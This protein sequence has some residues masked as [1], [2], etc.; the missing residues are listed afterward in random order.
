MPKISRRSVHFM[1]RFCAAGI[2]VSILCSGC[3]RGRDAATVASSRTGQAI[4]GAQSQR[5]AP[6]AIS[7]ADCPRTGRWALCSVEKR[8]EQS[9]FVVSR[10]ETGAHYRVGFSVV[11]VT[12]TLGRAHLEVFLYPDAAAA[13]REVAGLDTATAG[14]RGSRSQWP[15]PPTFVRSVNLIAVLLTNSPVQAERMSLALTAGPPQP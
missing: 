4:N 12:Y 11:P 7:K 6:S 1:R 3:G 13:A 9:G 5:T 2:V 8:L 15:T 10:V 14:P